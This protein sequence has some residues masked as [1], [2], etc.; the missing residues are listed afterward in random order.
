[1]TRKTATRNWTLGLAA[2]IVFL[3]AASGARAQN[4]GYMRL[5]TAQGPIAGT[6]KEAAHLNWIQLTGAQIGD[7]DGDGAPDQASSIPATPATTATQ[8]RTAKAATNQPQMPR[9][10]A[11]GMA[12]GKR[13]HKPLTITKEWDASSP[14]LRTLQASGTQIPT[15]EIYLPTNS[16][17]AKAGH[18]KLSNAMIS[19]I[20]VLGGG[21][22]TPQTESVTFTYQKIE[23]TY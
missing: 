22:K 9:D 19:S 10:H 7:V 2:G 18:Y 23:W 17:A 20:Q 6:S 15:V 1:M 21:G 12:T 3:C 4:A 14:K 13:M 11:S 5:V 16:G 8:G